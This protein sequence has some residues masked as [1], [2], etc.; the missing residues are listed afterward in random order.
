[1][2]KRGFAMTFDRQFSMPNAHTFKMKPVRDLLGI[3]IN[4]NVQASI[5]PKCI[6]DP[7]ARDSTWANC[8]ND[9]NPDYDTSFHMDAIEFC[10]M[11][12]ADSV[13]AD[14][15]LFDPPYSPRQ[16]SECY[17]SVGRTVTM[18]DTQSAVFKKKIRDSLD[19]ILKPHGIAI[20]F[21]W[22]SMGFGLTRG[23]EPL[24][25]LVVTHGGDHNDTLCLVER[26]R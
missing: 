13:K 2:G 25:L 21:G 24:H 11:L 16:I 20:S 7:F 10:E 26:K 1:M 6:V 23:Y 19:R 18:Q 14:V 17:K 8:T 12:A 5:F 4:K 9:L 3:Y 15:V 22:N